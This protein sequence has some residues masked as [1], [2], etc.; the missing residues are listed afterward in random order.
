MRAGE[1]S[2]AR[3]E[4]VAMDDPAGREHRACDRVILRLCEGRER[5]L[6]Q[7]E[8][9]QSLGFRIHREGRTTWDGCG[10]GHD[11]ELRRPRREEAS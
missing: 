2:P 4:G 6:R 5:G 11:V 9:L 8:R 1:S 7:L 3:A 10:F